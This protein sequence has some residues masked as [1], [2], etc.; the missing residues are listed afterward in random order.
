M[1]YGTCFTLA[2]VRS[3]SAGKSFMHACGSQAFELVMTN[4]GGG[5]FDRG[6][7]QCQLLK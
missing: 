2:P 6:A 1:L 5:N 3:S 4:K 7:Y